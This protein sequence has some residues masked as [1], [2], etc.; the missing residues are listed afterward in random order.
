ML[1][2]VR[3][4]PTHAVV[5]P[6]GWERFAALARDRPMPIYAIGGLARADLAEARR[7][8]AHGVA[9]RSAAFEP[10]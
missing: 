1:G 9:L 3:P 5:A 4:T 7:R 10:T 8:G 2:P 6:L